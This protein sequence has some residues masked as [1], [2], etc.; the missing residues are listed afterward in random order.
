MKPKYCFDH[1]NEHHVNIPENPVSKFCNY[2]NC[3]KTAIYNHRG[4]RPRFYFDHKDK[5]HVNTSKKHILCYKHFISHS[6]KTKCPQC[7]IKI[8][9]M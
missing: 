3:K 4:M 5:Y 9:K 1:K 8:T 7:K 6:P 2:D